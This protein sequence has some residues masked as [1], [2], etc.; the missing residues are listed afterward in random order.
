MAK[1]HGFIYIVIGLFIV[2]ASWKINLN[3]LIFFFYVGWIF[4]L[5]GIIKL[6]L[7]FGKNRDTKSPQQ[8]IQ[9]RNLAQPHQSLQHQQKHHYKRCHRCGNVMRLSDR[10]CSKCGLR[11]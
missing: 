1:I 8:K 3:A 7:G 11:I 6:V 9:H 5:I 10:F 4:V 2:L